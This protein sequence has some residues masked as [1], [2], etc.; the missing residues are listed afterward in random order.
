MD[1]II[2]ILIKLTTH[3]NDYIKITII[4]FLTS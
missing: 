1:Y 4:K 3:K 2:N